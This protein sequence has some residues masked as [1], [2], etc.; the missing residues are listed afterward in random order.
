MPTH[1]GRLTGTRRYDDSLAADA[2]QIVPHKPAVR[3]IHL[4]GCFR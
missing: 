4:I 1:W 3:G 2:A